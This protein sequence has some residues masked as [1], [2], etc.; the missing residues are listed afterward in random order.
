MCGTGRGGTRGSAG[1][2]SSRSTA[3][4]TATVHLSGR[5]AD[6]LE[7]AHTHTHTQFK[8]TE[9]LQITKKSR[10]Y[11]GLV[12]LRPPTSEFVMQCVGELSV[13]ADQTSRSEC[14]SLQPGVTLEAAG[15][16]GDN[17]I[18]AFSTRCELEM[19]QLQSEFRVGSAK[20]SEAAQLLHSSPTGNDGSKAG[21]GQI[22]HH[23]ECDNHL[24]F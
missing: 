19:N 7:R 5:A 14:I 1:R 12:K 16:G 2:C 6:D 17:S 8:I 24:D 9:A 10:A 4:D 11:S 18:S 20:D 15:R 3:S 13:Q 23:S 22:S 21:G